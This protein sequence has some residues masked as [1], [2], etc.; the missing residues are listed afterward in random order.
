MSA[1][2]RKKGPFTLIAGPCVLESEAIGLRIAAVLQA[3]AKQW[4]LAV[5]FKAFF[6]KANRTRAN[7]PR[8][9]G[10]ERGLEILSEIH[11]KTGLPV[12]TDIHS[13]EQAEPAAAF[14][15]ALQIPAFLCRQTDLLVA[16][17]RTGK[18]IN[19][20]KGQQMGMPEIFGAVDKVR[21]AAGKWEHPIAVTERGSFF[22]YGDLVVDM[23]NIPRMQVAEIPVFY[24][25]THSMQR[26][27][28][29]A[30][31][32]NV[33][34]DRE[35][36]ILAA[37]AAGADGLFLEVHPK[38]RTSP[39]DGDVMLPLEELGGLMGRVMA[40][41]ETLKTFRPLAKP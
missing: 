1:L 41:R 39:S 9:P 3:I 13:E 27:G 26:P 8:G 15:D 18:P 14:C 36:L 19:I 11:R 34:R 12:L 35:P 22:G 23:R 28:I 38:P 16:A 7:A 32:M 21:G 6:D 2:F 25:G 10:F 20:K 33:R 40:L 5:I 37:V 24:D 30:E 4:N 17:A 31:E 29:G